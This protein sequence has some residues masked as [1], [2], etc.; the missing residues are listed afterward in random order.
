MNLFNRGLKENESEYW[1]V[2]Q[3]FSSDGNSSSGVP[4]GSIIQPLLFLMH[5]LPNLLSERRII[6]AVDDEAH[7]DSASLMSILNL[8]WYKTL[9]LDT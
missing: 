2:D 8:R 3:F 4:Q 7:S 1:K 5:I 6:F 9:Q